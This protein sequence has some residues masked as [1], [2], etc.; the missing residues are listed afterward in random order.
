MVDI[1]CAIEEA[2]DK[3]FA[4]EGDDGTVSEETRKVLDDLRNGA[5]GKKPR[6]NP[7]SP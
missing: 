5:L 1:S 4:I 7:S 6:A 3:L 2:V